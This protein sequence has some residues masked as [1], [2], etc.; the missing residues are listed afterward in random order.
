MNGC[1]TAWPFLPAQAD[2]FI[3]LRKLLTGKQ[4][5]TLCFLA[6][7]DSAYRAQVANFFADQFHA[8]TQVVIDETEQI[9]TE[10]LFI[11]LD[12]SPPHEAVQLSGLEHWPEGLDNLLGRLNLRREA[13]AE[14]CRRPL[15]FWTLSSQ[16]IEVATRAADLWAWRS[17]ILD[18]ALPSKPLPAQ[19]L[20]YSPVFSLSAVEVAKRRKRIDDVLDYVGEAPVMLAHH[21]EML[22]EVGRLR[23]DLGEVYDA[24]YTYRRALDA[25]WAIGDL[26][27]QALVWRGLADVLEARG[28][29]V[30]A[31]RL[32]QEQMPVFQ[33][34]RDVRAVADT[35]G[36]IA[37]I[38]RVQG[39]FADALRLLTDDVIP[40]Y[41]RLGDM[42]SKAIILGSVADIHSAAGRLE[43]ALRI[44]TEER[45][46]VFSRLGET[47]LRAQV[48]GQTADVLQAAGRFDEALHLHR[49]EE[50]PVY[51]QLEDAHSAAVVWSRIGDIHHA[52]GELDEALHIRTELQLPVFER[53]GDR[54]SV[55]VTQG[56]IA[57]IL[58]TQGQLDEALRLRLDEELP[59]YDQLGDRHAK[60]IAFGQVAD[61]LQEQ[62]RLDEALSKR[63]DDE[64][65][66]YEQ[67]GDIRGGGTAQGKM[68]DILD[69]LGR[70]DEAD[71]VRATAELPIDEVYG[72]SRHGNPLDPH[73]D[74]ALEHVVYDRGGVRLEGRLVDPVANTYKTRRLDGDGAVEP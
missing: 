48:Q 40:I 34:L 69:Q 49:K 42:R 46:P 29:L 13:L 39:K 27:Q 7:T 61:L 35:N 20:A 4:G 65:P 73:L 11:R 59:L 6:F 72:V 16:V 17:C 44:H 33:G 18:F 31:L 28:H 9:G 19:T 21:V 5:F 58:L 47:R 67:L 55:A 62:G 38:L 74:Q 41:E 22:L 57:E 32:R 52:R 36:K 68:A 64:I 54:R 56:Q 71:S 70:Q 10:E 43:E 45:L 24:E 3:R 37:D 66:L 25:S 53:L 63:R 60:A 30:D 1:S 23:L 2:A 12:R 8:Y 15:L 14:R 51:E 26:R 50:L